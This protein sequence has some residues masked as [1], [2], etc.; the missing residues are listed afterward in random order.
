MPQ[1]AGTKVLG[2][3]MGKRAAGE[4]QKPLDVDDV[5]W[6]EAVCRAG[7]IRPL[8]ESSRRSGTA[9]SK[10]AQDLGVSVRKVYRMVQAFRS[11]PVTSSVIRNRPGPKKGIRL[12]DPQVEAIISDAVENF[13]KTPERPTIRALQRHI[14]HNCLASGLRP[15]SRKALVARVAAKPFRDLVRARHG[16]DRARDLLAPAIG[17][18]RT[19]EPLQIVQIDHTKV[20]LQLTD[21]QFREVLGRPYLTLVLELHTRT[22]LGFH[23]SLDP[24]SATS[25]AL[26]IAHAVLPKEDWLR[27]RDLQAVWPM[28]GLMRSIH[29]DNA[30]EFHSRALTRGC[31]QHGIRLLYRAPATP[32]HGGH[33]ER[34]MGTLMRRI[35]ELPGTTFSNVAERGDY[36]SEKKAILTLSEFERLLALE[37]V[38]PYHNDLHSSLRKTPAAAWAEWRAAGGAPAAPGDRGAFVLDF[39][40]FEQRVVGREG[41]RLFSIHYFDGALASLIGERRAL[42]VKYDPRDLSAVFVEMPDGSHL[43]TPYADLGRPAISLWEHRQAVKRLREE[44]RRTVDE[45]AIFAAVQVQREILANAYQDSKAARRSVARLVHGL[46]G[47]AARQGGRAAKRQLPAADPGSDDEAKVP[48]LSDEDVDKMEFWS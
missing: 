1:V 2:I 10:A 8:A 24:P 18:I 7:V 9:I 5:R 27:T 15:P 20:D 28:C 40:P 35:H 31:Q 11:N 17:G 32:H 47:E 33:I 44:G 23:V 29:L 26:A 21:E 38:G 48:S 46:Q 30:K 41:I 45:H 16:F 34:M 37:V 14:R 42:R 22:V 13:Y 39:L 36:D 25:V 6:R 12:L 43:R 3:S 4:A 19:E